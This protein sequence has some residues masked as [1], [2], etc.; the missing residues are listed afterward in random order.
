MITRAHSDRRLCR[1]AE[2]KQVPFA[3][4]FQEERRSGTFFLSSP[5]I[6]KRNKRSLRTAGGRSLSDANVH[7]FVS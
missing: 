1:A 7:S 2:W 5:A 4:L 3:S 6:A